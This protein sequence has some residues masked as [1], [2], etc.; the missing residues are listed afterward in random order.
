M[1]IYNISKTNFVAVATFAVIAVFAM[2]WIYYI[3]RFYLG[4]EYGMGLIPIIDIFDLDEESS[5]PTWL[6]SILLSAAGWI[7]FLVAKQDIIANRRHWLGVS[8]LLVFLSL[9]EASRVHERSQI[10][11]V[12]IVVIIFAL[13][14]GVRHVGFVSRI[15]RKVRYQL[16]FAAILFASGSVFVDSLNSPYIQEYGRDNIAYRGWATLEEGL[17]FSGIILFL[18]SLMQQLQRLGPH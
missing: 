14:G 8:A 6:S 13:S 2:S 18:K 3:L 16:I 17:E 9:D 11:A 7:A 10:L 15:N 4:Y 12:S 1:T 5:I